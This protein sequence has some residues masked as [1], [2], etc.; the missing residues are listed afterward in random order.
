VFRLTQPGVD[1]KFLDI[2]L[3]MLASMNVNYDFTYEKIDKWGNTVKV[4]DTK[5]YRTYLEQVIEE[6]FGMDIYVHEITIP[7]DMKIYIIDKLYHQYAFRVYLIDIQSGHKP[8]DY[9]YRVDL[10]NPTIVKMIDAFIDEKEYIRSFDRYNPMIQCKNDEDYPTVVFLSYLLT[11]YKMHERYIINDESYATRLF[12]R[13]FMCA[14]ELILHLPCDGPFTHDR[15]KASGLSELDFD[16]QRAY[17]L[18]CWIATIKQYFT[19]SEW[20]DVKKA[21]AENTIETVIRQTRRFF[22][23]CGWDDEDSS[24]YVLVQKIIDKLK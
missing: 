21:F 15:I 4:T 13:T 2:Y 22:S 16:C 19:E 7:L 6:Q 9:F 11:K 10:S 18:I 20:N 12:L 5:A 17:Y 8:D 24:N 23:D 1:R 3:N 14:A